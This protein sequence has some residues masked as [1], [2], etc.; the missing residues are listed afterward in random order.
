VACKIS[1]MSGMMHANTFGYFTAIQLC[2]SLFRRV[3]FSL[4]QEKS[5][6]QAS[7]VQ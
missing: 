6:D 3:G 2:K 1:H 7:Y 5:Y 4:H